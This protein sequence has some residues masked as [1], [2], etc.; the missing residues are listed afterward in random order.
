M[1]YIQQLRQ[2]E[3]KTD[4]HTT[5]SASLER[6]ES[7]PMQVVA[8][9]Q[10][11]PVS[12]KQLDAC[13]STSASSAVRR[14]PPSNRVVNSTSGQD[15]HPITAKQE[16]IEP[17][18]STSAS[19]ALQHAGA[20]SAGD[21]KLRK[22]AKVELQ[23]GHKSWYTGVIPASL[24]LI[25]ESGETREIFHFAQLDGCLVDEMVFECRD[26]TTDKLVR[27]LH[28][29]K[30]I[31]VHVKRLVVRKLGGGHSWDHFESGIKRLQDLTEGLRSLQLIVWEG[32]TDK[33]LFKLSSVV[34]QK[35]VF[36]YPVDLD[37]LGPPSRENLAERFRRLDEP[38][39]KV[40][41]YFALPAP[42]HIHINSFGCDLCHMMMLN[43]IKSLHKVHKND[44]NVVTLT[45]PVPPTHYIRGFWLSLAASLF[46]YVVTD[47][48]S[49]VKDI[50]FRLELDYR[51]GTREEFE[52]FAKAVGVKAIDGNSLDFTAKHGPYE[53]RCAFTLE[54]SITV[55]V[56]SGRSERE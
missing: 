17:G 56:Y 38:P 5:T 10:S 16:Q 1:T 47:A 27:Q 31:A 22:I 21:V 53:I 19:T 35:L 8:A 55:K 29:D 23:R 4:A 50:T 12:R 26:K 33:H 2:D 30:S 41:K 43:L 34:H 11:A 46:E 3:A 51:D 13:P 39:V 32:M 37:D 42:L 48:V 40:E 7:G 20:E 52:K 6:T 36:E 15:S 45:R 44:G 24:K 49:D 14:Q 28:K 25:E 54:P 18:P 9:D